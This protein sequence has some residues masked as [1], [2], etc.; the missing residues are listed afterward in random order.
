MD[1]ERPAAGRREPRD[2]AVQVFVAVAVV[3]AKPRLDRD[4]H[5]DGRDHRRDAGSDALGLEHQR[6]TEAART[7]AVARAAD[8]QVDLVVARVGADLRRRRELGR[9]AAAELQGDGML[10]RRELEETRRVAVEQRACRDHLGVEPRAR[11]EEPH[12]VPE[13]PVRAVHHRRY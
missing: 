9:I 3:D 1:D 2:E 12:E 10:G 7:H 11:R 6:G 13:M 8:V 5:V 4:G